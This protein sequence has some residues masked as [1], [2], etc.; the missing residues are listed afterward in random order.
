VPEHELISEW[1]KTP[2]KLERYFEIARELP[3]EA[4]FDVY[5]PESLFDLVVIHSRLTSARML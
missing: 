3:D 4:D 1:R 5:A 2:I